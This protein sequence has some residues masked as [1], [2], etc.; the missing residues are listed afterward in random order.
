MRKR[1]QVKELKI[2]MFVDGFEKSWISTPFIKHHFIIKEHKQINKIENAGIQYVYID[3]DKGLDIGVESNRS[4]NLESKGSFAYEERQSV[5]ET[6]AINKVTV[7]EGY[8]K[9]KDNYL[10]ID[11]NSLIEGSFIDFSIY[12]K[13]DMQINEYIKYEN[14]EIEITEALK[15]VKGEILIRKEDMVKYKKYL[16]NILYHI[17]PH[18]SYQQIKSAII[19]ENAKIA[20]SELLENPEKNERVEE[21]KTAVEEIIA[22]IINNKGVLTHLLTIN[23]YDYYTYTHSVNTCIYSIGLAMDIGIRDVRDLFTIGIGTLLHDIGK[24]TIPS[25]IL[26]KPVDRLS[27]FEVNILKQHVKEGF[28]LIKMFKGIPEE[29]YYPLLQHHEKL[30]GTGYPFG[31]REGQIHIY[32]KITALVNLYDTFTTSRPGFK[33]VTPFEALSVIRT[34][35]EDYDMDIFKH[36]ITLL[37]KSN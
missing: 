20:V 31:I 14:L 33:A 19:K 9:E 36:F 37:G 6:L 7:F 30:S 21:C 17:P 35:K 1:I 16:G 4:L 15:H 11:Q 13:N 28:K 24:S 26:N 34:L 23:K 3:T 22:D 5:L 25:E 27:E 12:L 32:G 2:G 10:Q 18:L 8:V 29:S